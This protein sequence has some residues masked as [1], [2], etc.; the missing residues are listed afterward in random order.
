MSPKNVRELEEVASSVG[1]QLLKIG[2][3]IDVQWTASSHHSTKAVWVDYAALHADFVNVFNDTMRSSAERV[4]Y[5]TLANQLCSIQFVKNLGLMCDVLEEQI[6]LSLGLQKN[7]MNMV[8]AHN[9]LILQKQALAYTKEHP[10]FFEC[11]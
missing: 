11:G 10:N 2:K 3:I 1:V 5:Q 4:S 9:K 6:S 8:D 7:D